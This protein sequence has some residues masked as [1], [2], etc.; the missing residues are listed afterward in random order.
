MGRIV[1]Y[2]HGIYAIEQE[3][4]RFFLITGTESALLL[5]TGAERD[6]I[7]ALIREV[8]QLPVTVI[9]TH[10][11]GD[12]LGNLQD[13]QE[14][15][16]HE[17]DRAAAE[18]FPGCGEIIYRNLSEGQQFDLGGRVLTV[19]CTPGHTPGSICLIDKENQLLF[20]GDTVSYGPV[21]MFGEGR[22]TK[23]YKETLKKLVSLKNQGKYD[24]VYCC[25]NTC[26]IAAEKTEELLELTEDILAGTAKGVPAELPFPC[27]DQP[28]MVQRGDCAIL[29]LM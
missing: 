27:D 23:Q 12:H 10:S 21:F 13:F 19:I 2:G 1:D 26:P 28:V 4:V 22:D 25:H 7:I 8:T 16:V 6:D 5:D 20:S 9:L 29:C 14:V 18:A 24:T 3:I 11:D 15:F 17:A